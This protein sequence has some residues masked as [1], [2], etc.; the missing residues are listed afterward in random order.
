[1]GEPE[2]AGFGVIEDSLPPQRSH[3][4]RRGQNRGMVA[5]AIAK[6]T[7]GTAA[8]TRLDQMTQQAMQFFLAEETAVAESFGKRPLAES[9]EDSGK[10]GHQRGSG[11]AR[12]Q[13]LSPLFLADHDRYFSHQRRE[14][15]QHRSGILLTQE[16]QSLLDDR[17]CLLQ[18]QTEFCEGSAD[19]LVQ[20]LRA[21]RQ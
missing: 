12:R 4:P 7:E 8:Y 19:N 20:I 9:V 1:M 5:P 13:Q 18:R 14:Q 2:F 10:I 11:F 3:E 15:R 17:S 6:D 21:N 16:S